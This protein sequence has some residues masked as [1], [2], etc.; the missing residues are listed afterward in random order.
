MKLPDTLDLDRAARR[1]TRFAALHHKSIA[2]AVSV[3]LAGFAVTAFSIA[4]RAPDA[5]E[6]PKRTVTQSI[7]LPHLEEQVEQL[8]DHGFDLFRSDLTRSSDTA[9]SLLSRLG[10]S[11][12]EA[13]AFLRRDP[14]ARKLLEGRGGK[15]VQVR[16][17]DAG[18]LEELTA[19]FAAP[20]PRAVPTAAGGDSGDKVPT[21]F[22]RLKVERAGGHLFAYANVAALA[23]QTLM[24]SGTVRSSFF[25]ATDD[26]RIPDPVAIQM[27]E[28]FANDIDFRHELKRG[29]TFSVVYESLTADGEAITWGSNVGRV[30]AA[31]FVNAGE[32]HSAVWF[33]GDGGNAKGAYFALDGTSKRRAF[34][35]SPLEFSRVT[36]GFA[37]RIHPIFNTWKQH[38][39]VDYAAPTG[40]PVRAVGD[41]TVDFAGW[42]NGYGNVVVLKHGSD[43][44]T[45][46]AHLSSLH[47]AKGERVEQGDTIGTVGSTGFATGPHLHFEV[48]IA[49]QLADPLQLAQSADAAVSLTAALKA[50]L[51]RTAESARSQL[52]VAGTLSRAAYAGE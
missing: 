45:T 17:D 46:Y 40:T 5:A 8:A 49:G 30:L 19:R 39:G 41:A 37:M 35:A 11:D 32:T 13:A 48:K 51:G 1:V 34:L 4:P 26:A 6:L 43:R 42:Q 33:K 36:S 9:D 21:H 20:S 38:N 12:P 50:Q 24:A 10:V 18:R 22:T 15:M 29:A 27:A 23:S 25:A 28:I 16:T 47:V 14:A 3:G 7:A 44:L 31:E 2:A 52:A